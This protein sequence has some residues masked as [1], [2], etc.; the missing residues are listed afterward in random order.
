VPVSLHVETFNRAR[1]LYDRLGFV[2]QDTNGIY[3]LMEWTPETKP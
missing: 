1:R 3:A 2:E